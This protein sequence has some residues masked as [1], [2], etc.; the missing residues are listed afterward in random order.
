MALS[1]KQ[2]AFCEYYASCFNATESAIKGKITNNKVR[3]NAQ[4]PGTVN[5]RIKRQKDNK[6]YWVVI[7]PEYHNEKLTFVL[8]AFRRNK[9]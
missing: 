1:E 9:K 2:K 8:T 3:Q 6:Q 5:L 7:A 4:K